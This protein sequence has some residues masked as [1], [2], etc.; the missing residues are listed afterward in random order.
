M[1]TVPNAMIWTVTAWSWGSLSGFLHL[2]KPF[3]TAGRPVLTSL[4]RLQVLTPASNA[5]LVNSPAAVGK[6]PATKAP[7][8]Y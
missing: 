4:H 1:H 3:L 2:H 5:P 6:S 8:D 7:E